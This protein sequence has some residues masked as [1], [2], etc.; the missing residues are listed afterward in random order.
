MPGAANNILIAIDDL[1]ADCIGHGVQAIRIR[2][3]WNVSNAGTPLELCHGAM[4]Y[5]TRFRT[6]HHPL[7][8]LMDAGVKTTLNTDDQ[9]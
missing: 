5:A 3:W 7:K 4:R 8:A 6:W 1:G 9:E 2:T